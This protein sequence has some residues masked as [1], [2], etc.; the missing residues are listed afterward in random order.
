MAKKS[1]VCR[2]QKRQKLVRKYANQ[3]LK[4]KNELKKATSFEEKWQIS[5]NFQKMP[6]NSSPTRLH[7]RCFISGRP[8]AYYRFFGLSRHFLR[9]LA[10]EGVLPGVHKASW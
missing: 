2:E 9:K 10:H 4:L 8:K 5:Q 7:N 6:L 1:M 3:R